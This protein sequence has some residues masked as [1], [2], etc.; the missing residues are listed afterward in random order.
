[1]VELS[2]PGCSSNDNWPTCVS[3]P[4]CHLPGTMVWIPQ[5]LA[6]LPAATH[7]R[8]QINAG[9]LERP[10]TW[11][12]HKNASKMAGGDIVKILFFLLLVSCSFQWNHES[13][14]ANTEP[15]GQDL[16]PHSSDLFNHGVHCLCNWMFTRLSNI[17]C[18]CTRNDEQQAVSLK[19][20]NQ[21]AFLHLST[22]NYVGMS[23]NGV[24]P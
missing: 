12:N 19:K 7:H 23:E 3:R 9:R 22:N 16:C 10:K 11:K 15:A 13:L 1:M 21:G 2:E 14:A 18:T 8:G 6:E 5:F 20:G 4:N 24:Y 17:P